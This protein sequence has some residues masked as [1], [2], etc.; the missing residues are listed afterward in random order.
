MSADGTPLHV[1]GMSRC[2]VLLV[3][4]LY[5][6]PTFLLHAESPML[7]DSWHRARTA[8]T[9]IA[10]GLHALI[11]RGTVSGSVVD[12]ME[13][14]AASGVVLEE[15]RTID[16]GHHCW[17]LVYRPLSNT[18]LLD[19]RGQKLLEIQRGFSRASFVK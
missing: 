2:A 19:R 11:F 16:T 13:L 1:E 14:L 9:K 15:E 10:T 17:S 18:I 8:L 5:Y 12:I 6:G 7:S 4:Q 3:R